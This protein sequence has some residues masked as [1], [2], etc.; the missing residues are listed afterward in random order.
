MASLSDIDEIVRSVVEGYDGPSIKARSMSLIDPTRQH[1]AVL[2]V[3]DYPRLFKAGIVV[4]AR[5]V[6]DKVVIEEDTTDRPLYKELLRAGIPREQMV[7]AYAGEVL[8]DDAQPV[9][10]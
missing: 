10:E 5:V 1:Y 8:P 2:M 9:V 7:L 6:G 4:M 3:P